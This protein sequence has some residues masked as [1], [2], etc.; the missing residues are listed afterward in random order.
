LSSRSVPICPVL[1]KYLTG[2]LFRLA[3]AASRVWLEGTPEELQ[4]IFEQMEGG[5]N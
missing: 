2:R 5:D 1:S 3:V 4:A